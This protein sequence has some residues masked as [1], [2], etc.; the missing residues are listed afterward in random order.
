[1][2]F[3]K[4]FSFLKWF[5][6]YE[7]DKLYQN[8]LI[9]FIQFYKFIWVKYKTWLCAATVIIDYFWTDC[10]KFMRNIPSLPL[11]QQ[12]LIFLHTASNPNTVEMSWWTSPMSLNVSWKEVV[13]WTQRICVTKFML[14]ILY[15]NMFHLQEYWNLYFVPFCHTKLGFLLK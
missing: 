14:E 6:T 7:Y 3:L 11:K 13:I 5:S 1:M 9:D 10:Y 8:A 2:I 4:I 12:I 15:N